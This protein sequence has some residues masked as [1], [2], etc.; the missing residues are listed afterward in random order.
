MLVGHDQLRDVRPRMCVEK[1]EEQQGKD[2][3]FAL[4]FSNTFFMSE[5]LYN[6]LKAECQTS[7]PSKCQVLPDQ[8]NVQCPQSLQIPPS[9]LII[10]PLHYYEGNKHKKTTQKIADQT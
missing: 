2:R 4:H 1:G 8:L 10:N 7:F 9:P 5:F 6:H 3:M